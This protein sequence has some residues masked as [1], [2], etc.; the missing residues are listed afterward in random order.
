RV[1]ALSPGDPP[2]RFHYDGGELFIREGRLYVATPENPQGD[3]LVDGRGSQVVEYRLSP[4]NG[5]VAY[6]LAVKG[7]ELREWAVKD[8]TTGKI[9]SGDDPV[10]IRLGVVYWNAE[11]SGFYYASA[12]SR[13]GQPD[14]APGRRLQ[15][16]SIVPGEPQDLETDRVMFVNPEWPNYADWGVWEGD[17]RFIA[18]RVQGDA[19]IPLAAYLGRTAKPDAT[20]RRL[21]SSQESRLGQF[22]TVDRD[23]NALFRTS[24]CAGASADRFAIVA[25]NLN[26]PDSSPRVVVPEHETDVL[27][28]ARRVGRVLVLHYLP[29]T[30]TSELRFVDLEG[31][32]YRIMPLWSRP[33][34]EPPGTRS[35]LTGDERSDKAYFTYESIATPPQTFVVDLV[36]RPEVTEVSRV[37]RPFDAQRVKYEWM[38]YPSEDGTPVPIQIFTRSDV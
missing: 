33:E 15:F 17:G 35:A 8:L 23:Q 29:K 38:T 4:D 20:P 21:F 12:V 19:E 14:V 18:Y 24:S 25:I 2:V 22:V 37:Q 30:L 5:K 1:L 11:S 32:D 9:L 16:R 27:M 13:P 3:L 34:S 6:G 28:R 10:P 31:P 26:E 7:S 36:R